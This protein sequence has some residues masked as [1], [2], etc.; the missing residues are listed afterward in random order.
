MLTWTAP[1]TPPPSPPPL[2]TSPIDSVLFCWGGQPP[3]TNLCYRQCTLVLGW[4]A[5]PPTN[6]SYGQR[7]LVLGWTA[8]AVFIEYPDSL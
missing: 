6:L 5:P 2:L 4:T 8:L 1:H 3:P 7:A